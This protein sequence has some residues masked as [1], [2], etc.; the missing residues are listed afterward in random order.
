MFIDNI[1]FEFLETIYRDQ[2]SDFTYRYPREFV[3]KSLNYFSNFAENQ[4]LMSV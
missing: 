4:L 3:E 2:Y 1:H